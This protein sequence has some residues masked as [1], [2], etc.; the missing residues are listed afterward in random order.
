MRR[1]PAAT[2]CPPQQPRR[3]REGAAPMAGCRHRREQLGSGPAEVSKQMRLH[4]THLCAGDGAHGQ[5]VPTRAAGL[6]ESNTRAHDSTPTLARVAAR[7][8]R[9]CMTARMAPR[10]PIKSGW[11]Q[12]MKS[13]SHSSSERIILSAGSAPLRMKPSTACA[14]CRCSP[15]NLRAA[16]KAEKGS[17]PRV[18]AFAC[19]FG[20]P[21]TGTQAAQ[22]RSGRRRGALGGAVSACAGGRLA[23]RLAA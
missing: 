5:Q 17:A 12:L 11:S 9:S 13:C 4:C 10:P 14:S 8:L 18:H 21:A 3:G 15:G 1:W 20:T 19:I 22:G 16:C 2:R 6:G 23:G 7:T